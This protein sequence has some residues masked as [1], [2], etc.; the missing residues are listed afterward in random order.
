MTGHQA[1][2]MRSPRHES[3]DSLLL[4]GQAAAVSYEPE[5][6]GEVGGGRARAVRPGAGPP[7]QRGGGG[8]TPAGR[9]K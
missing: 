5:P 9:H 6:G 1:L 4:R 2:R 3:L 8:I 7:A